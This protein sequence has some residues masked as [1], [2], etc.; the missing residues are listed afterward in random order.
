MKVLMIT[1]EWPSE[2]NPNQV[3]F[4]VESVNF[5]EKNNISFKI[6]RVR[7]NSIKKIKKSILDIIKLIKKEEFNLVHVHWGYNFIYG[8]FLN[9]P[10]VTTYHGSDLN[11]PKSWTIKTLLMAFISRIS[12]IYSDHNIFVNSSLCKPANLNR[13]KNSIIP[14]GVNLEKFFPMDKIACREKLKLPLDKK[15]ILFGGNISQPVKRFKLAEEACKDLIDDFQLITVD[16]FDYNTIPFFI[17]ASDLMLVTSFSEGSP[18]MVKESLACNIPIVATDVG[19]IGDLIK[20]LENCY[21]I[22]DI[23]PSSIAGKISKCLNSPIKPNGRDRMRA[24]YSLDFTGKKLID[25]YN[26]IA[27]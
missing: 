12:T 13:N 8:C 3:P 21:L 1:S 9:L 2:K 17:N 26:N 18:M 10:L 5:L 4:L 22:H 27:K 16:Y 23:S 19:D 25:I 11:I 24:Y 14:M 6:C 20:G 7:T 15:I